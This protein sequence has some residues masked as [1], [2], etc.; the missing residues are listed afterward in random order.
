MIKSHVQLTASVSVIFGIMMGVIGTAMVMMQTTFDFNKAGAAARTENNIVTKVELLEQLRSGR[1][2]QA[3][4]Q[5]EALLDKDLTGAVESA[6]GGI[7]LTSDTLRA[8]E[9]ERKA[10]QISGYEPPD[11]TDGAAAQEA[12]RLV[13]RPELTAMER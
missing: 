2:N 9:K 6:R 1:Y 3:T 12:F 13:P 8:L 4:K 7:E 5:L 10:R 11:S